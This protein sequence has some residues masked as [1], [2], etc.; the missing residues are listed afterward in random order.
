[1]AA[2]GGGIRPALFYTVIAALMITNAATLVGLT[3]SGDIA[4]L[5]G[6]SD[7]TLM[8][9]YETR[10]AD[11]RTEIDRLYSRQ[12]ARTGDINL[13]MQD[14]VQQQQALAEQ[15]QYVHALV[16]MAEKMGVKM[17]K[18]LTSKTASAEPGTAPTPAKASDLAAV[19]DRLSAM[20][21]ESAQA[22]DALSASVEKS[23]DTLV[24]GLE[25][26]GIDPLPDDQKNGMG[27]P[28]EPISDDSS[29]DIVARANAVYD[30]FQRFQKAR[31]ALMNAPVHAPLEGRLR[32]SSP[33][34]PRLD[35][36]TH[37]QGFHSGMDFPEPLGT[38]VYSAGAGTVT[39]AGWMRGYGNLIEIRHEDGLR[40]RYGHLSA[41]LVAK[42]ET[43]TTGTEIGKIGT[44]GRSTGPHLHFE[45]RRDGKPT[46]PQA[47]L[48]AGK[49]LARF[50]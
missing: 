36:F 25:K 27:G 7:K 41:I 42:G 49:D 43:V 8:S 11:L 39:Y 30:D 48:T 45:V 38:P 40:T 10:I 47:Y 50:I 28:F 14:V 15:H 13:Q 22:L 9:A 37:A 18:S 12:Y 5:F 16:E 24:A 23:T 21:T 3:M 6:A 34:G 2:S 1:M 33:F 29:S 20:R 31:E 46:N 4:R 44:T 26:L 19:R 32:V 35:P 17:P